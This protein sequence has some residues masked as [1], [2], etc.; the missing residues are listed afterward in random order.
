VYVWA[1]MMTHWW[2]NG[3]R[4]STVAGAVAFWLVLVAL[5]VWD[6]VLW[7]TDFSQWSPVLRWARW[8]V[9]WVVLGGLAGWGLFP[10]VGKV[11]WER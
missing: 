10:Q 3:P 8:P 9:L 5:V 4:T 1:G 2:V 7:K 11:P 6:V